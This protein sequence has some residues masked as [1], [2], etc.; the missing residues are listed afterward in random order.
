MRDG[1]SLRE[2]AVASGNSKVA[3]MPCVSV[4]D[5]ERDILTL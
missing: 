5:R 1:Y 2:L 4:M 3:A